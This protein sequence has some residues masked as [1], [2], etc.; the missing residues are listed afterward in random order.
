M[1]DVLEVFVVLM[2]LGEAAFPKHYLEIFGMCLKQLL[3]LVVCFERFFGV[4]RQAN[5]VGMCWM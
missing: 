4:G 1:V 2:L 3:S 5:S